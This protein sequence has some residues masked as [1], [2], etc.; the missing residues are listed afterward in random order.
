VKELTI[1]L[2]GDKVMCYY[3]GQKVSREEFIRLMTLEKEVSKYDFLDKDIHNGFAY[4]QIAVLKPNT[5][6]DNFEI[7]QMEWG[8]L[9]NFL[10]NRE[11]AKIYRSGH[12]DT[13]GKWVEPKPNLNA[14]GENLFISERTGR[15]SI[16]A[17]AARI[18]RCLILSTGFFEWQHIY[19]K[20]KRTGEPLKTAV[21][22]PYY[23]NLR[24]DEYFFMAGIY[25][26]WTDK[27]TGEIVETVAIVT[28]P[29]NDLMK[30]IHNKKKRMPTILAP[31]LAW[32]WMMDD[33]TDDRIQEIALTQYDYKKMQACSVAKNFKESLNPAEP[34]QYEG[35]PALQ[36]NI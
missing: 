14:K 1:I 20:N 3:N 17:D 9:G 8:F 23:I 27:S 30:E 2:R 26:E 36:Y 4:G 18:G 22:Y 11:D 13:S 35:L 12:K 29:G 25:Q 34:F 16:F 21:A 19:P 33:L 32:E 7:V 28:A 5:A 31:D 6:K 15:K 10:Q 24:E